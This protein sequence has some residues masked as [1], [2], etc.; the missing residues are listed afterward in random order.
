MA[1]MASQDRDK[2]SDA[3]QGAP[4]RRLARYVVLELIN[5]EFL[6][7]DRRFDEVAD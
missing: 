3:A 4:R 5:G 1:G 6:L 2:A 7:V